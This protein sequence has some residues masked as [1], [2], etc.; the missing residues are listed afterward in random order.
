MNVTIYCLI[1][2][3]TNEIRYVG[4]TC[5]SLKERLRQHLGQSCGN[6]HKQAWLQQLKNLKL[7]PIIET[8]EIVIGS[9]DK[10][11]QEL[12]RFWILYLK[13]IG[14]RLVNLDSGGIGGKQPSLETRQKMRASAL[15]RA[16]KSS[17][18]RARFSASM[19][20]RT[21]SAETR[22]KISLAHQKESV[23]ASKKATHAGKPKS[24]ECRRKMSIAATG[25]KFDA[26]TLLKMSLSHR[27]KRQPHS[28]ETIQKLCIAARAREERKRHALA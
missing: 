19:K 25:R 21:V 8:L 4:K 26:A 2:P 22:G 17:E 14:G 20:G 27:G 1:D 12:E 13:F 16:P 7:K 6:G 5:S 3:R 11:W 23:V 9:D 18:A 28:P 10:D 24:V 15:I